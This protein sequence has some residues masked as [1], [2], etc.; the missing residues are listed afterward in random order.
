MAA[1][2]LKPVDVV[3]VGVGL[4]GTIMAKELAEAGL[5]VVGLE[6]GRFPDNYPDF[7]LPNSHDQGTCRTTAQE[8]NLDSSTRPQSAIRAPTRVTVR[9]TLLRTAAAC[10]GYHPYLVRS[11]HLSRGT[12][13]RCG[14]PFKARVYC[15]SCHLFA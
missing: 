3:L 10:M 13:R 6:R 12:T 1:T 4:T 9:G 15:G 14:T 11:G 7:A 2:T 8:A 5:T